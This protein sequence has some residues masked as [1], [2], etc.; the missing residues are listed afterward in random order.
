MKRFTIVLVFLL[1]LPLSS[2]SLVTVGYNNADLYLRYS[3]NGYTTFNDSQKQEIK[4]EV[5]NYLLWHRKNM[6]PEYADSLRDLVQIVQSGRA[7]NSEDVLRIKLTGRELYVKTVQPAVEP[8]ASLLSNL[9]AAQVDELVLSFTKENNKQREK[10][11]SGSEEKQLRKRAERTID[12]IENMVGGLTD[13]QIEKIRELSFKL[14][15]TTDLFLRLR[16]SKQT[17]LIGLLG[18]KKSGK[19]IANYLAAW[20]TM[21]EAGRSPEAQGLLLSFERG[22]DE[23]AIEIYAML[24]KQQKRTLEKNMTK[25]IDAFTQL[26]GG[27]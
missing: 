3:I 9:D 11:L 17:G 19:E 22:A 25:Y 13:V 7:L 27:T 10:F 2:C 24:D 18:N 15:F 8:V 4:R 20:L 16:E 14:P 1:L 6:L 26:A 12:F 23:M 21:P 5:D